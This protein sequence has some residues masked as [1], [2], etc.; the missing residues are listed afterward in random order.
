VAFSYHQLGRIAEQQCDFERSGQRFIKALLGFICCNDSHNLSIAVRNYI[1][2]H[3][4]ADE[5]NQA[6]LT[7]QWQ[8]AGLDEK[9]VPLEILITESDRES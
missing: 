1:L 4:K 8:Q 6:E 5:A 3:Q 7:Q 9:I 2:L